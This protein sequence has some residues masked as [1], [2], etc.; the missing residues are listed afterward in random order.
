MKLQ[1]PHM[2]PQDTQTVIYTQA[3][4]TWKRTHSQGKSHSD[5]QNTRRQ[6][7]QHTHR[8]RHRCSS[9]RSQDPPRARGRDQRKKISSTHSKGLSRVRSGALFPPLHYI[10]RELGKWEQLW[11][12]FWPPSP[13]PA[14]R[15]GNSHHCCPHHLTGPPEGVASLQWDR[16]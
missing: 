14:S 9:N 16:D 7:T 12:C 3:S 8:P 13:L 15:A 2:E 10:P 4:H 11:W 6:D 5:K 1:G